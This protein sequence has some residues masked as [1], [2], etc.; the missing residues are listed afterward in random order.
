[1]TEG[2]APKCSPSRMRWA[3]RDG[4]AT[5][6]PDERGSATVLTVGA[7]AVVFLFVGVMVIVSGYVLAA[8][9]AGQAADL[10]AIS[11]AASIDFGDPGCP[12]AER[13][14][15]GNGA[16]VVSCEHVGDYLEFAVTVEIA[17]DLQPSIP[18]L[19]T[20]LVAKATAGRTMGAGSGE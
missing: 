1:M 5:Q 12:V 16:R 7:I 18:G 15:L 6:G 2:G 4:R 20:S 19:P 10:A 8:R 17:L 14:A 11:A 9:R 3:R 13:I